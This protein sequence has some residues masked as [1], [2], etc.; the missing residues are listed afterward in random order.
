MPERPR[1]LGDFN[2]M[3]NFQAKLKVTFCANIYGPLDGKWLYYN[4]AT[5]S[6]HTKKPCNRLYSIKF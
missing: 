3:G 5:G 2:G 1:D 4:F 6:Y